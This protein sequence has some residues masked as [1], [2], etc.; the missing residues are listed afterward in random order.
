MSRS[1]R[2]S[3]KYLSR[4]DQTDQPG[5]ESDTSRHKKYGLQWFYKAKRKN[6]N[7]E[8]EDE[9]GKPIVRRIVRNFDQKKLLELINSKTVDINETSP[10]GITALHEAAIDGNLAC[11]QILVENGADISKADNEGYTSLDYAVLGGHFDCAAFLIS[12]G[13]NTDHIKN[14]NPYFR[15]TS[16]HR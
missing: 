10:K 1:F 9:N 12:K 8:D 11:M 3:S 15:P 5:N 14:G 7:N 6:L 4:D 16:S 13:S 2:D